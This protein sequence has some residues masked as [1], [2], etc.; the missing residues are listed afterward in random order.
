ML[1]QNLK[2][3]QLSGVEVDKGEDELPKPVEMTDTISAALE[4]SDFSIKSQRACKY[5]QLV[6]IAF[7]GQLNLPTLCKGKE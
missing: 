1:K 6:L 4:D 3:K 7:G 2:L 5:K